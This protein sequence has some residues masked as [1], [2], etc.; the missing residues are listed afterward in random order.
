MIFS[1]VVINFNFA[2]VISATQ[3]LKS[4]G[5]CIL[6]LKTESNNFSVNMALRSFA[7]SVS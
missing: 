1:V 3:F 6:L 2:L 4:I 5:S 7:I